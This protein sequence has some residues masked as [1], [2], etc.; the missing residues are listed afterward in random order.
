MGSAG[1]ALGPHVHIEVRV[2][3][4]DYD[5]TRNP[6][7]WLEPLPEP[8]R[9]SAG[10]VL[11]ADGRHLPHVSTAVLSRPRLQFPALL[12]LHLRRCPGPDLPRRPA[13]ARTSCWPTCR[14]A[15][16]SWKPP[17]TARPTGKRS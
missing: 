12:H 17:S 1:I 4:N 7:F 3:V 16:T 6:E 2:G 5:H 14:P 15:P 11:T 10:R 8:R 9:A 13:G